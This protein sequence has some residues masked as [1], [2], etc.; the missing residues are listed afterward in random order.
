MTAV[1]KQLT[2]TPEEQRLVFGVLVDLI[3][4]RGADNRM[5]PASAVAR[6]LAENE[7]DN[8]HIK[9]RVC[10]DKL[11]RHKYVRYY[12]VNDTLYYGTSQLGR[13]R[14]EAYTAKEVVVENTEDVVENTEVVDNKVVCEYCGKSFTKRGIK[15]HQAV[16]KAKTKVA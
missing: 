5:V 11:I 6:R 8:P 15:R 2:A 4:L 16:C 7:V 1:K 9:T 3:K 13:E 12:R 10:L 14:W